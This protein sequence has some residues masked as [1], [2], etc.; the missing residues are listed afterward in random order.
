[1]EAG[2][3]RRTL[4]G[5]RVR[6]AGLGRVAASRPTMVDTGTAD[7]SGV[8]GSEPSR[9]TGMRRT[10]VPHAPRQAARCPPRWRFR[11]FSHA[12]DGRAWMAGSASAHIGHSVSRGVCR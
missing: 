1:M 7:P 3:V 12:Y 11:A 5:A 2:G 10:S 6:H 8:I 4:A 9:L